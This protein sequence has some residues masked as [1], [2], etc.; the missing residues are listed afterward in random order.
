[1]SH[2]PAISTSAVAISRAEQCVC[3]LGAVDVIALTELAV[4]REAVG[5]TLADAAAHARTATVA[6]TVRI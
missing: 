5:E 2:A 6:Q 1:M 3:S 4:D